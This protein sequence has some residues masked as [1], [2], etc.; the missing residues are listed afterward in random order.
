[1]KLSDYRSKLAKCKD[2]I[3]RVKLDVWSRNIPQDSI[4]ETACKAAKVDFEN[5][6]FLVNRI[7]FQAGT[8]SAP[9]AVM[10]MDNKVAY[11]K[12]VALQTFDYKCGQKVHK[13][14][15]HTSLESLAWVPKKDPDR[16]LVAKGVL[17]YAME[18][19]LLRT[20]RYLQ[21]DDEKVTCSKNGN[22]SIVAK[23]VTAVLQKSFYFK[24]DKHELGCHVDLSFRGYTE[25]DL[26]KII[27]VDATLIG[28]FNSEW[29]GMPKPLDL[30]A[31]EKKD[32]LQPDFCK[33]CK[34]AGHLKPPPLTPDFLA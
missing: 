29:R 24:W 32:Y 27:D 2:F 23:S 9:H 19:F 20:R 3:I 11:D 1:M 13:L 18:P 10:L 4:A 34:Q 21:F 6:C 16:V 7:T 33:F 30:P 8:K 15:I 14:T 28:H 5:D 22:V 31:K 17:S 25:E 12:V 26:T